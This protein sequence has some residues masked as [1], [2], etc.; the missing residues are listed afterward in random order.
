MRSQQK[1]WIY[2]ALLSLALAAGAV[3]IGD[4]RNE[5]FGATSGADAIGQAVSSWGCEEPTRPTALATCML[6]E[7]V[8]LAG[9]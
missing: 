3:R 8:L 9:Q 6:P 5:G 1:S 2:F 4:E 7:P